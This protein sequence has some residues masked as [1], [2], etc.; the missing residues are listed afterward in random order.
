MDYDHIRAALTA[1]AVKQGLQVGCI[2]NGSTKA[3]PDI[4]LFDAVNLPAAL[5]ILA[6]RPKVLPAYL[7]WST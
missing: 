1:N 6:C 2:H 5:V 7:F 4:Q 3:V